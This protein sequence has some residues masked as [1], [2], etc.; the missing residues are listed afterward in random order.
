MV[1][2]AFGIKPYVGF[3]GALKL[4]DEVAVEFEVTLPSPPAA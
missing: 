2:S 4:N 3:F 1:Q